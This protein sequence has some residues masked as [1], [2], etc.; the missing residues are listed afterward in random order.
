MA[1]IVW[2]AY[3]CNVDVLGQTLHLCTFSSVDH[4]ISAEFRYI[5]WSTLLYA[6]QLRL[7]T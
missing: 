1:A 2:P 5:V 4:I 6:D 7:K 3:M